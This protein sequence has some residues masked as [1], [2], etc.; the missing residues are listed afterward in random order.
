MTSGEAAP[1]GRTETS[2]PRGVGIDVFYQPIVAVTTRRTVAIEALMRWNDGDSTWRTPEALEAVADSAGISAAIGAH[3]TDIVLADLA[4]L[5]AMGGSTYASINVSATELSDPAYVEGLIQTAGR[6][7]VDVA[8]LWIELT[9]TRPVADIGRLAEVFSALHDAGATICI[10]D[11]HPDRTSLDLE[12]LN[13]LD[14]D[15]VKIDESVTG[16]HDLGEHVCPTDRRPPLPEIVSAV[17]AAGMETVAEGIET[18]D[19]HRRAHRAG[20]TYSQG[21]HYAAAAPRD[22]AFAQLIEGGIT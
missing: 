6:Y 9:A 10:D 19:A 7:G 3:V 4:Y 5:N 12:V 14:V 2:R 16:H 17:A 15:I 13:D 18:D 11:Y 1:R 22:V 20:C 8:D 21:C